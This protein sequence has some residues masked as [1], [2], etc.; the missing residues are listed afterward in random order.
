MTIT[1]IDKLKSTFES[2]DSLAPEAIAEVYAPNIAFIDPLGRL[3]GL[4]TLTSYL[5]NMYKNVTSCRF[6]YLDEVV[7]GNKASIKWDMF[8]RHARLAGG[9]QVTLR[10]VSLIEFDERIVYQEDIYDLGAMMYE[11]IPVLSVPVK[12]IKKRA[13]NV[14]KPKVS[15]QE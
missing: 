10:G 8:M 6:E 13:H 11:N 15:T 4:D 14:S 3:D 12:W 1:V 7:Q 9:E 5:T 2:A